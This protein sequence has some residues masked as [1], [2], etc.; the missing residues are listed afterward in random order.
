MDLD[1]L[2]RKMSSVFLQM[3]SEGVDIE[4]MQEKIN[5]IVAKTILSI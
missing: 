5:D 1:F 4:E 2:K 3:K